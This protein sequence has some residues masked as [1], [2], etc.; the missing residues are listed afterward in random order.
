MLVLWDIVESMVMVVGILMLK[1]YIVEDVSLN[2]FV[3]GIFF[4]KGVV[5]VIRGLFNKLECYEFE[6]VIVYEIFY[7]CNYDI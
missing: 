7:I 2:V 1:V 3:M 6:G 5:V 4:E